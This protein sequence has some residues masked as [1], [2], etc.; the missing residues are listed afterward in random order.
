[1]V[2]ESRTLMKLA[3]Y[4]RADMFYQRREVL[5]GIVQQRKKGTAQWKV[6]NSIPDLSKRGSCFFDAG[7]IFSEVI[8]IFIHGMLVILSVREMDRV[9]G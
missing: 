5:R 8:M 7:S 2:R 4:M 3:I 1:M 6:G 9:C